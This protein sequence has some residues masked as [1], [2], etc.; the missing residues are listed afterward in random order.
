MREGSG[1]PKAGRP[2]RTWLWLFLLVVALASPWHYR[3]DVHPANEASRIY[4][5]LAIVEHGTLHL[6]PV[7]DRFFEGWRDDGR[8]PNYDAA[9]IDGHYVLDKAPLVSLLAVPPITLLH[10]FGLRPGFPELAWGVALLLCALPTAG[11]AWFLARRSEGVLGEGPAFAV[12]T[13]LVLATPWLAYGGLLFGHAL[14]ACLVGA[15]LLLALGPLSVGTEPARGPKHSRWEPFWGG[16]LLGLAV[17]AEFPTAVFAVLAC[18]AL[19]FDRQRRGRLPA[20]VAGGL[21]PAL[22]LLVWNT[23]AFGGPFEMSYEH[24]SDPGHAVIHATGA[25]GVAAPSLDR[26]YQIL[27]GANRGLLFLAPWLVVGFAGAVRAARDKEIP[28]AWRWALGLG[29]PGVAVLMS[30]FVDWQAGLSMGPRHLLP[31]VPLLGVGAVFVLSRV[32]RAKALVSG[33]LAGLLTSSLLA[34]AVGAYVFPY[35]SA[36]VHN[37]LYEVVV[38]VLLEGGPGPTAWDLFFPVPFGAVA[39]VAAAFT[40]LWIW[41]PRLLR[42][43]RAVTAAAALVAFLGHVMLGAL[44][45]TTGAAATRRVLGDRALAHEMI[46]QDAEA[47]RIREALGKTGRPR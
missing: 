26:L 35:F 24:K 46:G 14:S 47:K 19:F 43:G 25:W 3:P 7:F 10:A 29:I 37:P 27:C 44:P 20:V 22:G 28:T 8:P 33:A 31:L 18:A 38:P 40:A 41:A 39:G 1:G 23:L 9:V 36:K 34:C 45:A 16:L 4:A 6:D 32:D 30:G 21:G 15:G 17:L 12:A 11:F 2:G 5:A 13:G 42:G